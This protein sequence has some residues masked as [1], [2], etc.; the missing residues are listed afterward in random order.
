MTDFDAFVDRRNTD[1]VKWDRYRDT[2]IIPLWVADMD[3][4]SPPAV[5]DALQSRI[6]HDLFGYGNAP[7]TLLPTILAYLDDHHRWSVQPEWLVWLPGL[8]TGIS[9]ACRSVGSPGDAVLTITPVYPPFLSA[10]GLATRQLV[11]VP[12]GQE[13]DLRYTIDWV[14]LE[15]TVTPQT[16]LL[17]LCNPHNPVGRVYSRADL[18]RLG[19]FC[20]AHDLVICADEIHAGLILDSDKTHI[21]IASLSPALAQRT[22]T[23]LA[24]SKTFNIPGLG[25]SFAVIPNPALRM[26][27]RAEMKGIVPDVNVLAYYAAEAA[28]REGEAWRRELIAYLRGNRD[29]VVHALRNVPELT[30]AS[31]EATYLAWIDARGLPVENPQ[32]FFERAGVG[33][34]DGA[35]FGAPGFVR[36]NF[37]CRRPLLEEALMRLVGA[38]RGSSDPSARH[39]LD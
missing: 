6:R 39:P 19:Q 13:P 3:F 11:T 5:R 29:K 7:R 1:S 23:L 2:D 31:G 30:I 24:P 17:L 20:E 37:G 15:K 16:R 12:L 14:A 38:A 32:R 22:I 25:F 28:Y 21:S 8:V 18:E 34:S 9:L 33:L 4:P 35:D 10:P 27:F 36:L 26:R